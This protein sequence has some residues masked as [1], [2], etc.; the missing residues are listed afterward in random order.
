MTYSSGDPAPVPA[1]L[2]DS[3]WRYLNSWWVLL[4]P[5]SLGFLSW[6]AFLVAAARSGL[7]ALWASAAMYAALLAG[8][9]VLNSVDRDGVGG[10]VAVAFL[11]LGCWLGASVH[12]MIANRGFLR[13]LAAKSVWYD[14]AAP[15]SAPTGAVPTGAP[16]AAPVLGVSQDD[17]YAPTGYPATPPPT[18][19][20]TTPPPTAPPP[21][22]PPPTAHPTAAGRDGGRIDVNSATPQALCAV[23]GVGEELAQRIIAARDARSGLRDL[24]DLV[25]AA[26]LQPHELVRLRDRLVFGSSAPGRS[27]GQAGGTGRILDI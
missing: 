22:A 8:A 25:A 3:K 11:L 10:N 18:G 7:K 6:L 4:P 13:T 16:A 9:T 2:A 27:A 20:P 1:R 15:Q 21:T 12:A 14:G 19:P 17:Y 24:D 26:Q 23:P 5:L